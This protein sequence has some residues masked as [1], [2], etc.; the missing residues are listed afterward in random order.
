MFLCALGDLLL[1][2]FSPFSTQRRKPIFEQEHAE[3]AEV[4]VAGWPL[5]T[6]P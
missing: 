4:F 6:V 3:D 5:I 1:K 2:R